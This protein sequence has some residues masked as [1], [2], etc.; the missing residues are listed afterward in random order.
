MVVVIVWRALDRGGGKDGHDM[1][2]K[3]RKKQ[4]DFVSTYIVFLLKGSSPKNE[5]KNVE[6]TRAGALLE[7]LNRKKR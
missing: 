2:T 5:D 1:V 3:E 6:P 7:T 4:F